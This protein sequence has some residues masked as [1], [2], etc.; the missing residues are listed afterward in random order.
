[1]SLYII[2]DGNKNYIRRDLNGKYVT[3]KNR[4]LAD[5]FYEMW[6]AQKVL[7]NNITPKKRKLYHVFE[8][9]TGFSN[10]QKQKDKNSESQETDIKNECCVKEVYSN[11]NITRLVEKI[12]GIQKFVSENE[13]RGNSLSA[14]LSNTDKE[15]TDIEHY[16]EFNDLKS[17]DELKAYSMLK[18]RLESRRKIKDELAILRQLADCKLDTK[19]I[20]DTL[21]TISKLDNKTYTPRALKEL[22]N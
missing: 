10:F 3:V 15:I 11:E 21:E 14:L 20:S 12:S 13:V 19:T 16:I 4:A 17:E 1:M 9:E 2:T 7:K 5:E 18:E 6:T 8:E 22:F